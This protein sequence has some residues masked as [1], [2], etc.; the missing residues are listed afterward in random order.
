MVEWRVM[1][2]HGVVAMM[3]SETLREEA[4]IHHKEF[5]R[6]EAVEPEDISELRRKNWIVIN[7]GERDFHSQHWVATGALRDS[8]WARGCSRKHSRRREY[9]ERQIFEYIE[10]KTKQTHQ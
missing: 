5:E 8:R 2:C 6:A 1:V 4:V 9:Y 10:G 3:V 7:H